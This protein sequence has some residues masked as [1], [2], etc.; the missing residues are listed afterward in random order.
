MTE[1]GGRNLFASHLFEKRDSWPDCWAGFGT[2]S[3]ALL[4][5]SSGLGSRL[6]SFKSVSNSSLQTTAI[7]FLVA[8]P[9]SACTAFR[10]SAVTII[11]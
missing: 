6:V 4:N 1:K 7:A 3:A 2:K 5:S 8:S 9:S 10:E 11:G